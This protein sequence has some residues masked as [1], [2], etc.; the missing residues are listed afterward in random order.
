MPTGEELTRERRAKR[1]RLS[2]K[3]INVY[4]PTFPGRSLTLAVRE[5]LKGTPPGGELPSLTRRV[6]GRVRSVRHLGKSA[7][8]PLRD[9]SGELQLLLSADRMGASSF[10]EALAWLDPGDIV[11]A[12]GVPLVSRRGEPSLGVQTLTLLAKALRVPPEKYHGLRDVEA[13]LRQRYID[14]LSSRETLERFRART[15]LVRSLRHFL[16]AEG[17]LEVET[18]ILERVASGA[19]A[20][21]F[22]TH[23]N[24][25]D[26]DLQLRIAL[27]LR[28]KRLLVG[29]FERVY[30]IGR[31]FRNEDLDS[32]HSPEFTMLELYWAYADYHDLRSLVERMLV[33]LATDVALYL[34]EESAAPVRATFTP[35]FDRIDFVEALEKESG[36]PAV[37]T[38]SPEQLRAKAR[39][40]GADVRPGSTVGYCL[41]KLFDHYVTPK[42]E[43]P[44]FVL[45]HP[46]LTTPL[47]KRHRSLPGRV[48][49]FEL[50]VH[51]YELGNAYTELN[52][53]DEQLRR[54]E[55]QRSARGEE[56]YALDEDFLEAMRYGMPPMTGVGLGVDRLAMALLDTPSIKEVVLFPAT[57]RAAPGGAPGPS[58]GASSD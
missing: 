35:P 44:T 38:L 18:P 43:R 20:R 48:E 2:A 52:D 54:F 30:E 41:D 39:E 34:P 16:D 11:G 6:A 1:D 31:V 29:G 17:F 56:T 27:E 57:K 28:L 49:R 4:P 10:E 47:A 36:L 45:D 8:V 24:F 21:P 15:H 58:P 23:Y 42:L 55:E 14:L 40:V 22:V 7:F 9:D 12:E 32:T 33:R 50:F 46:E 19:S 25:L 51:G 37:L 3:G 13:R 5:E 26:E 53:P